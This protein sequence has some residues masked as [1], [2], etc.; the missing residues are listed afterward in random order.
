MAM[1]DLIV[2]I[3]MLLM[4]PFKPLCHHCAFLLRDSMSW[5]TQHICCIMLM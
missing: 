1:L 4:L 5:D 2:D 3:I